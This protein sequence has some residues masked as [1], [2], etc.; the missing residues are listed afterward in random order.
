MKT[1]QTAAKS[2]MVQN[3]LKFIDG[4]GFDNM[5]QKSINLLKG[6]MLFGCIPFFIYL[7]LTFSHL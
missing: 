5:L 4:E 6:V 3:A 1:L 7:L 2:D